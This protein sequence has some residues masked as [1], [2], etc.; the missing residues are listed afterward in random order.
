MSSP[1]IVFGRFFGTFGRFAPLILSQKFR[2]VGTF[3]RF[4]T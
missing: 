4:E 3:G 1:A 2:N